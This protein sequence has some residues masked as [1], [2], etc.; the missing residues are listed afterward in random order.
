MRLSLGEAG[1][2]W[3]CCVGLG[4]LQ[5]PLGLGVDQ[6]RPGLVEPGQDGLGVLQVRLCLGVDQVRP[7]LGEPA[8]MVLASS[9]LRPSCSPGSLSLPCACFSEAGSGGLSR[10]SEHAC[11]GPGS[12]GGS[13]MGLASSKLVR[14]SILLLTM[15]CW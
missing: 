4:V 5:V 2:S 11:A 10:R 1:L 8:R 7:G 14:A 12:C 9:L 3:A 13:W 6:V 15:S